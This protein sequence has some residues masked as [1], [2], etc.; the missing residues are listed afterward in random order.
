[1]T[2]DASK[3]HADAPAVFHDATGRRARRLRLTAL[4]AA[5]AAGVV[6]AGFVASLM[7]LPSLTGLS[8]VAPAAVVGAHRTHGAER[9]LLRYIAH[10]QRP[11]SPAAPARGAVI[12][13]AWFAPWEDGALDSFV[14][15]AG[16][17]TH[18]YPT[19][20][21]LRDAGG[22]ILTKDWDPTRNPTT[23]P[24]IA[25]ARA[26]GVKIVPVVGNATEGRF[27]AGRID[28]MLAPANAQH[29]MDRLTDFVRTNGFAGLQIDFEQVTPE[30]ITRLTPWLAQLHQRLNADGRELSIA[31]EV[32]LSDHDIRALSDVVDYAAIMAYDEHG[33]DS[34]PGPISSALFVDQAI[35]RFARL[36][37]ADKLILGVGA[38]SYDWRKGDR[39]AESLTTTAALATAK[40][41]RPEDDP[42][43]VVDFDPKALQP[44]FHYTDDQGRKHEVWMQDAASV[45][46]AMTMGR[47]RGLR[48]AAL[49]AL[50]EEDPASWL[51]FGRNAA[52]AIKVIPALEHVALTQQIAFTGQGELLNVIDAPHPGDRRIAVDPASGLVGDEVWTRWPSAWTVRRTGAPDRTLA[53]TFDDGPD[54]EWTP[55]ILDVLKAKGVKATFFMIGG[56]ATANPDLV[57]RVRDEGHEIGNHSFTHPNMAHVDEERVRL[58]LTATDRALESILDR[59]VTLFRPPYNADSEPESYG[60]ILPIAVASRLGYTTAGESIDPNDW[61]LSRADANG[62]SH[63]LRPDEIVSEVL[64]QADAGH[65]ILLHDAGGDRSA[66]VKA[67]PV[68]I[69]ALRARG[70]RLTTIGG[71]V[72]RT[73]EQTM[74][75]L[76]PGERSLI[77]AD[78]AAFGFS[79]A[80]GVVLFVGFNL[81]IGLGLAR[82]VLML[83]LA[84]RRRRRAAPVDPTAPRPR[85]DVLVAAF[86][87][88]TVI[89][90]TLDS[91]LA[92][93]DVDVAV[94]VVD[95]GSTDGTYEVVAEAFGHDPRV[96]LRRKAN[97]GKASALNLALMEATAPVVVGVDAD[98]QLSSDALIRL[99]A[100]F[101]DPQVGAAAGNVK[102]GNRSNL[103]T[104]WQSIEYITSQNIDRRALALLNAVTVVPGAIGA[105]RT[106]VLRE[107][108]G[109]RSD[110]LAEDMDLTWR[111]RE[112]GW[113]IANEPTAL[114]FT[115][116]PSS[117][118]G[119]LKQRFRWS[120]GTLQ[121]L[122]KHRRSTFRHGWF[123]GLA[124]PSLWLFQIVGQVLAPLIDLQLAAALLMQGLAWMASLQH[125]DVDASPNPTLW[126]TLGVYLAFTLLE[127]AAGWVAFGFDR[128]KRGD[129]WLL[130]TQRFVYRQIMYVVV[131]RALERALSGLGQSWGKLKRTGDVQAP[132][133]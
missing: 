29:V 75:S 84:S 55:E 119:L 53:L 117:L 100:W 107:L 49:W 97:G 61:N 15:H 45:A 101:A 16:D 93:R 120:F 79:H 99:A 111:V 2:S 115:E 3:P 98:T 26:H 114:A 17:L 6:L 62:A 24:L 128:E 86:N 105:W 130:P 25:A 87:E 69:D 78:S 41:Y 57:R 5:I 48:G 74:P 34:L 50:G 127:L 118:G 14:R 42:S 28:R 121:C 85:V 1:M 56:N 129:L 58:E 116:A 37:P 94:L 67:L 110:T 52:P 113:V 124:L 83:A 54:P 63:R 19:W 81:A 4:V 46:N 36:V 40:G 9:A 30:Q 72:G 132:V 125:A 10:R 68:L 76:P 91:L 27:D 13:G 103:V 89:R 38:Y 133:G 20:I 71:L 60:E 11:V 35:A 44:T 73:P 59:Q 64:A 102:V 104:R 39:S 131:W 33:E 122:W 70:Y 106:D 31:L 109:Y 108:G 90:R 66:T 95:D 51:V 23:R 7:I 88:A 12:A 126:F 82:I 18:V 21:E 47:D 77:A 96:R 65:A 43:D 123:G 8:V 32:G 92:S 112:A 22:D 80:A